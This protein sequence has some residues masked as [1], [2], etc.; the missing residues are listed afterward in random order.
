MKKTE[1]KLDKI[2]ELL[3]AIKAAQTPYYYYPPVYYLP[4]PYITLP[5]SDETSCQDDC[6]ISG[7]T[8]TDKDGQVTYTH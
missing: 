8:Y 3:E 2:I 7:E 5:P 6:D 1:G 4:Q